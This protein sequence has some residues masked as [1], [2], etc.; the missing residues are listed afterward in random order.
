MAGLLDLLG[1]AAG[2]QVAFDAQTPGDGQRILAARIRHGTT[3]PQGGRPVFLKGA[4]VEAD[5]IFG[6]GPARRSYIYN[7]TITEKTEPRAKP[8]G[9][10]GL[11]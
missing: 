3:A 8:P 1:Q 5:K 4:A 9:H 11:N 2:L 6:G 7:T 10:A